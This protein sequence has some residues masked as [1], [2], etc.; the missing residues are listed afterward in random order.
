MDNI[1]PIHG[2]TKEA[3]EK[4]ARETKAISVMRSLFFAGMTTGAAYAEEINAL[5]AGDIDQIEDFCWPMW[6]DA[7]DDLLDSIS[8]LPPGELTKLF[9]EAKDAD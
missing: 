1:V 2:W 7:V 5:D 4:D 3:R 9:L 6:K 8:H